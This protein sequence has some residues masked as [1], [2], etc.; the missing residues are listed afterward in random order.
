[1]FKDNVKKIRIVLLAAVVLA[2]AL[3]AF[4]AVLLVNF[5]EP[6]TGFYIAGTNLGT[7]F[8]VLL[9]LI[10]ALVVASGVVL[11]KIDA[12]KSLSSASSV[13]VFASSLCAYLY[14]SLFVYNMYLIFTK[15][16]GTGIGGTLLLVLQAALCIPCGINHLT[17]CTKEQR[18]SSNVYALLSMSNVAFFAVRLISVFMDQTQQMNSSQRSL[19]VLMLCAMMMFY[20]SECGFVVD[21]TNNAPKSV[22]RY[23]A[24]GIGVVVL[25]AITVVPYLVATGFFWGN[26]K[27]FAIAEMLECCVMLFA[28]SRLLSIKE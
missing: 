6:D 22:A 9:A 7:V 10:V 8:Y 12:P 11:R 1:M 19:E 2:L 23:F 25:T 3:A 24:S 15:T 5:V 18:G 14:F 20:L 27:G 21:K 16:A 17:I 13:I 28:A 26:L 4:R